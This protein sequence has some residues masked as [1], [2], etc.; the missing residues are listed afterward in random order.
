MGAGSGGAGRG[1]DPPHEHGPRRDQGRL[2]PRADA[3]GL[4]RGNGAGDRLRRRGNARALPRGAGRWPGGRGAG[5]VALPLRH[6][7]HRRDQALSRRARRPGAAVTPDELTYDARGLI[8]AV[9]QEAETGEVLMVAWMDRDAVAKTLTSGVTHFWSRSRQAPWQKG[10][11]SG[12]V[13]HVQGV[14]ADC[15]GDTLV[16]QVH[17]EGVAC[18]TGARTCFFN[19][20]SGPG[21]AANMLER[22][23]RIVGERK[24]ASASGSYVAGLLAKGEA[25]VCRKIGEEAIEVVTAALG[26]EGDARGGSEAAEPCVHQVGLRGERGTARRDFGLLERHLLLG[27]RDR[28][29]LEEDETDLGGRRAAHR[30]VEGRPRDGEERMRI[31]SYVLKDARCV[32]DLLYV[33]P[34]DEFDGGRGDF[35]RFVQSFVME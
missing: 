10:E 1:R 11:T 9:V 30:V 2:R 26:G 13:Q 7:H 12:H 23:E 31:E 16:V 5:G 17:Q 28:A 3:C 18:H 24:S 29:T 14:Y 19:A 34:P 32:Y 27:L 6:P 4:R 35:R 15:D 20:L 22:I 33:A 25:A 8:P 21:A